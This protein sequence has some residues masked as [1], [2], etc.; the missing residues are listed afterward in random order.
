MIRV[1]MLETIHRW[2]VSTFERVVSSHLNHSLTTGARLLSKTADGWLYP[3]IPALVLALEYPQP[4]L[5][6]QA[7]LVA[8]ASERA[9]YWVVKNAFRRRRPARVVRGYQSH[10]IASDEFSFPSGHTSAAFM[11]VTLLIAFY[12]PAFIILY[13]WSLLVGASRVILGVHFPTDTLVGALM[14]TTFALVVAQ[15]LVVT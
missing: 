7:C 12:G 14:G 15:W 10:I 2:D 3:L 9:V 6:L 5:F 8:F 11:M 4:G 1:G 13:A